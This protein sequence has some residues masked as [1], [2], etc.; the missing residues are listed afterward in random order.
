MARNFLIDSARYFAYSSALAAETR[1]C[2]TRAMA[3][4]DA[5]FSRSQSACG[6]A[7]V[8]RHR[9]RVGVMAYTAAR[10]GIRYQRP[11][12]RRERRRAALPR[13]SAGARTRVAV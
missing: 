11:T 12:P 10:G 2:Q 4:P 7:Q 9:R 5:L 8:P 13:R 1:P 6:R 3:A